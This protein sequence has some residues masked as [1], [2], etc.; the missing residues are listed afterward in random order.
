MGGV[1]VSGVVMAVHGNFWLLGL[2]FLAFIGGITK[3]GILSH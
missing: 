3:F 1:L 2:G